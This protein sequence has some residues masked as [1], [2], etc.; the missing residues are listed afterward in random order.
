M[1]D[2]GDRNQKE[3]PVMHFFEG[4]LQE[5]D[6][7]IRKDRGVFYT[8]QPVVSF[9]VRSVDEQ[10]RTE[11]GLEDGLA[12]TTTWGEL[13][14]RTADL[15]IP[16]GISPDQAF[17]QILDPATGT[18]TFPAEV[19]DLIYKTMTAKWQSQGNRDTQIKE[20]WNEYVPEHLLPRLHGYELM[21]APYA[22]AHMKI[23]L[24][25]YETGYRFKSD[26]RASIYLTNALEPSLDTSGTFA[27]AIPALAVETA[28]VNKIKERRCF[29]VVMGNPPYSKSS[30]NRTPSAEALVEKY[31]KHIKKEKNT[32]P[33][34]DDYI[35]FLGLAHRCIVQ[36][37]FGICA[38]VTNRGYLVGLI[39]RGIRQQLLADFNSIQIF[40]LHGDSKVGENIPFGSKNENVFDIQ[41]GV[42]V[43]FFSRFPNSRQ[44]ISLFDL[45]GTRSEKFNFLNNCKISS[46]EWIEC[47]PD[48]RFFFFKPAL[49]KS[50]E[51]CNVTLAS[52]NELFLKHQGGIKTHR[53]A[54]VI[55]FSETEL[56]K[57]IKAFLSVTAE[58]SMSAI[59]RTILQ[60]KHRDKRYHCIQYRPFDFRYIFYHPAIIDRPR[61][62][63]M[64]HM[65]MGDN[66][67]LVGVRQVPN[68]NFNHAL[69]SGLIT[70][71]KTGSHDR[72]ADLFPLYLYF[73]E[74]D[75]KFTSFNTA[76][77]NGCS[78]NLNLKYLKIFS[79]ASGLHL[80]DQDKGDLFETI[81]HKNFF[82]YIYAVL[83][84]P[85]YRVGQSEDLR[86]DFAK[87]PLSGKK[88]LLRQ[89]CG[90]GEQLS[91]LHLMNASHENEGRLKISGDDGLAIEKVSYS[92]E[93][94]WVNNEKSLG[95][96]GVSDQVW[97]FHIG[98]YQVCQKWLK[99][100][101]PKKGNPGRI[102]TKDDITH[103]Q[104]IIFSINETILIMAEIDEVIDAHGGWPNAFVTT[105][106]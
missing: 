89:L 24:K 66:T 53:D 57:K 81:G 90:L 95:F 98:G 106:C 52:L 6:S 29:T 11:F 25:L 76:D 93:T 17:V 14:E 68:G 62:E 97:N 77:S 94:I 49:R 20:L 48:D 30:A 9:I 56:R 75:L 7:K 103:Y 54:L 34:S 105:D 19:I 22:I 18:G 65:L 40:D 99:D 101:G 71:M 46:L 47:S 69:V 36:S 79:E 82:H 80:V 5:Y 70:E 86:V 32:Q 96:K 35:K 78:L 23:G 61:Q 1:R 104:N 4:F 102:L 12:D 33:L 72:G 26:Q 84:S 91:S 67:A 85:A 21:M 39:H 31:K 2:F 59:R 87:I 28:H 41:Q 8:P 15:E 73:S 16:E 50:A 38:M 63:I 64:K 74:K 13:A 60:D 83:H 92:D 27:F 100:R 88:T 55:D 42:A 3:D 44:K 45:W 37:N 58:D 43:H 10:L 51:L